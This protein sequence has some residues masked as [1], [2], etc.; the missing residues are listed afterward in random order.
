MYRSHNNNNNYHSRNDGSNGRINKPRDP[1]SQD[2]YVAYQQNIEQQLASQEKKQAYRR[3]TDHGNNMGRWYIEKSLG[4]TNRSQQAIGTIRPESSY[5]I[6]LLPSLAYSSSF[7]L[8]RRNNKNNL[9][10][11]DL[12]TKFVHLSSNKVKHTINTVKWTPE[13]RRLLVASHSGEFTLWN[14][15][16]FNFETIMQAH[17]SPILTMKYSNHDEWLL[18]GDQNGTVKYWQPNFN[19]VNNI[20]AHANGVRDIAFSPND[21]KFLTC[22]DDSAIKIWNFNNGK[23]ERTLSGHHWEVKSADWHPNLGLIVSGSKDNLVKL[24]DPRSANCVSTLHGFKHTVNKTRFQPNGT[25]RLLASVSRDRSCRIFDLRTMKDMLV[26]RDSETDLSCVAWHPIH[27]SMVTTAAYNGSI[28]NFLLDSYIPD[29]NESVPKRSNNNSNLSTNT[30]NT[31]DAVQKI[32][33]AHEKA[34]HAVEYHPL[35]H[36]L[37]T[38]GSDKTARFWSRARPNDPMAWKDAVYTDCKAG[39]WYYS[40]N[41]NVNAVMEDPNAVK[42]EDDEIANNDDPLSNS[43]RRRGVGA[44][45]SGGATG[46]VPGLRSRNETPNNGS[47]AIPG[48]RGF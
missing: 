46:S 20:S 16:T 17:E 25:A 33:Y 7:N 27:A 14:G 3:I 40:V 45:A 34:I 12:Q 15:M 36:L 6:D 31:I 13:G 47:Y 37:C 11:L 2:K 35:G 10:V 23:E 30:N 5:L 18:S 21:S 19:N 8:N 39:A 28:S 41:N 4:L 29:S 22:G 1:K 48:L 43:G 32:P 38:A 26:I 42:N 9:A 24:W 44:S